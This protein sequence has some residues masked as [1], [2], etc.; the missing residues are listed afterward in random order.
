MQIWRMK[1]DGS[2]Q[3][4]VT[5][6]DYNNWFAHPSPDGK[7]IVFLTY[8]KG[9]ERASRQPG[10]AVAIDAVGRRENSGSAG[11]TFRRAG[12]DQCPVVVAG[13]PASGVRQL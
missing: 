10:R 13:Q 1:P 5:S 11:Q 12:D 3:E 9:G 7:W 6:D 4:Q 8:A 2:Q